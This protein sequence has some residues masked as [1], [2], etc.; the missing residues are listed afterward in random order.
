MQ[1]KHCGRCHEACESWT[2]GASES[3]ERHPGNSGFPNCS[4]TRQQGLPGLP[5]HA[6][7]AGQ[8]PPAGHGL[9]G[10][11]G[12]RHSS[13]GRFPGSWS[14]PPGG[15][16]SGSAVPAV[17]IRAQRSRSGPTGT[18]AGHITEHARSRSPHGP[19]LPAITPSLGAI[20]LPHAGRLPALQSPG[21]GGEG[22]ARIGVVPSRT[23]P[24]PRIPWSLGAKPAGLWLGRPLPAIASSWHETVSPCVFRRGVATGIARL[25]PSPQERPLR[26]ATGICGS[27]HRLDLRRWGSGR[28][29]APGGSGGWRSRRRSGLAGDGSRSRGP[30]LRGG[31]PRDRSRCTPGPVRTAPRL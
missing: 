9:V 29:G 12:W 11:R 19:L 17:L 15:C 13:P 27:G 7:L 10:R 4:R 26:P 14:V 20:T 16:L 21:Q 24:C 28:G 18:M 23:L 6:P 5:D 3:Y 8:L 22:G 2:P 30:P 1:R 25:A 31:R